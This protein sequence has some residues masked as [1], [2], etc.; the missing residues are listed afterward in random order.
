M[1][2]FTLSSSP[3]KIQ[4]LFNKL[5]QC[6]CCSSQFKYRYS[7]SSDGSLFVTAISQ[8][9]WAL[10]REGGDA[11]QSCLVKSWKPLLWNRRM[12]AQTSHQSHR[13]VWR[14]G[15][16]GCDGTERVSAAF[17]DSRLNIFHGSVSLSGHFLVGIW[18]VHKSQRLKSKLKRN[19]IEGLILMLVLH[20]FY[21]S[22]TG[23]IVSVTWHHPQQNDLRQPLIEQN[24]EKS[25][26]GISSSAT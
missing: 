12:T 15:P 17:G 21:R 1:L 8:E 23:C 7:Y 10:W 20:I 13:H 5:Q 19:K 24:E 9:T 2:Q 18:I 6:S 25:L 16:A 22:T 3:Q 4:S 14:F 26:G 11:T